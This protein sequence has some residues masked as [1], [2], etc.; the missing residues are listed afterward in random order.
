MVDSDKSKSLK[1][2][3]LAS[4]STNA[5][6]GTSQS[7]VQQIVDPAEQP[8]RAGIKAYKVLGSRF[9]LPE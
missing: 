2:G 8:T 6:S 3:T 1:T 5:A 9:E 7:K 4:N